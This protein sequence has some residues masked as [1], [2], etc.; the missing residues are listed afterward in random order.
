MRQKL[1]DLQT[2]EVSIKQQYEIR[3]IEEK[4][5]RI[6]ILEVSP[7]NTM[8]GTKVVIEFFSHPLYL[9]SIKT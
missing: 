3:E 5:E 2:L 7:N 1:G 8:T 4:N 6:R 9:S